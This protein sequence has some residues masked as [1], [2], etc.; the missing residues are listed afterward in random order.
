MTRKGPP[1]VVLSTTDDGARPWNVEESVVRYRPTAAVDDAPHVDFVWLGAVG[2]RG[3][4]FDHLKSTSLDFSGK[5]ARDGK[6][7]FPVIHLNSRPVYSWIEYKHYNY[8][9]RVADYR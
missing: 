2:G 3:D 4:R 8:F 1:P 9:E 5:S 6:N 7:G